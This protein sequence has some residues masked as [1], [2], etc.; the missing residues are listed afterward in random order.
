MKKNLKRL[1]IKIFEIIEEVE[2]EESSSKEEEIIIRR[3]V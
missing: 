2:E 3:V 1:Y